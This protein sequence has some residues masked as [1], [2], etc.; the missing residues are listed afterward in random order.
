MLSKDASPR[1][2]LFNTVK[3]SN[4]EVLLQFKR[5]EFP[6]MAKLDL[7]HHISSLQCHMI[8]QKTL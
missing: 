8:N 1:L 6:V 5:S 7:Q 3:Q 4:C 2:H